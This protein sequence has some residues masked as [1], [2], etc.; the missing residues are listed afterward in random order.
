M[1]AI[2]DGHSN[3]LAAGLEEARARQVA[4]SLAN[5]RGESVWL[6]DEA[7]GEDG[8][9]E[10]VAP[11][12]L[13]RDKGTPGTTTISTSWPAIAEADALLIDHTTEAIEQ[14]FADYVRK[15][16]VLHGKRER[17]VRR[18]WPERVDKLASAIG[19]ALGAARDA[20]VQ[21]WAD[22]RDQALEGVDEV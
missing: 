20:R 6:Y 19:A 5:E 16:E 21:A 18:T 12:Y 3:Q 14:L 15:A 2:D 4:Q 10:E 9:S 1:W 17:L 7:E 13:G 8:E 22:V 11:E